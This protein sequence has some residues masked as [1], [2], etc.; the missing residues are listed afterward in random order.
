V[1]R[2]DHH[3]VG[4]LIDDLV[5]EIEQGVGVDGGERGVDDLDATVGKGRL[6]PLL[7]HARGR[8][9]VPVRKSGRGGLS[10]EDDAERPRLLLG[11]EEIQLRDRSDGPVAEV[12]PGNLL[13]RQQILRPLRVL[14]EERI[15]AAVARH[16]QPE[17]EEEEEDP[18]EGERD[19][20]EQPA[21]ARGQRRPGRRWRA[22]TPACLPRQA[23]PITSP[24]IVCACTMG[25]STSTT[26]QVE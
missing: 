15:G 23:S 11:A 3:R 12:P 19:R 9:A 2:V 22:T 20:D 16:P 10:L 13:I 17:L 18:G 7:E 26:R 4:A 25:S 6:E 1:P 24:S 21:A 8:A 14:H 5:G